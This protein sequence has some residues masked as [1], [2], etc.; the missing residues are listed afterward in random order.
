[1]GANLS[2]AADYDRGAVSDRRTQRYDGAH[3]RRTHALFARAAC[4]RRECVWRQWQHRRRPRD[5][6][7]PRWLHAEPRQR[8][9]ACYNGAIYALAYDLMKDLQPVSVLVLE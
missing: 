4:H 7:G 2:V 3:H 1:M 6:R 9:L 5:P 8:E